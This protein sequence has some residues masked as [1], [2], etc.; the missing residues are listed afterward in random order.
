MRRGLT[1]AALAG[2]VV[3]GMT[4]VIGCS[5]TPE[6]DRSPASSAAPSAAASASPA[7]APT[8][9]P[10]PAPSP[11]FDR[12]RLSIDD[13][14]SIWVVSDKLRPLNPVEF[15][16]PDLVDTPVSFQ[17]APSLRAEPAAAMASMFAAADAEGAGGMTLQ[18]AYRSYGTQVSV[19][20]RFV[21]SIGRAAADAQSA[22][23]GHSEH[24][25]GLAADIS[26][27]PL[28]CVLQACFG[29]T[30]QGRWLANNSWRFGYILRYPADKTAVTGFIYEPWHFRYVGVELATEMRTTGI[31]TLEEFFGLPAAPDYAP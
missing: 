30:V 19:Y 12:S 16:P 10:T 14:A 4:A 8:S 15:V 29:E 11:S 13:P 1:R 25:T 21:N 5:G 2:I 20:T 31:T 24:Q 9:A 23:P 7:P 27:L 28:S 26:P 17:N 3:G 6:P 18:S 22:R